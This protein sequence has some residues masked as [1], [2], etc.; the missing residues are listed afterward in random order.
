MKNYNKVIVSGI[1]I[2]II[3]FLFQYIL[4]K[5]DYM[6]RKKYEQI[7]EQVN[8][9]VEKRNYEKAEKLLKKSI[10]Y[11]VE[12]YYQL[13]IFYFSELNDEKKAIEFFELGYKKGYILSTLPLEDIYRKKEI[14]KRQK[15][16]IKKELKIMKIRAKFN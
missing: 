14:L 9:M 5:G 15:N 11:D 12:G 8:E 6:N 4:F 16:G 1:G 13:G 3:L 7:L 2:L 10:K